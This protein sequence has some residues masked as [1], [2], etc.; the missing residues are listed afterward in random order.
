MAGSP[1]LMPTRRALMGAALLGAG[2]R[3]AAAEPMPATY[4]PPKPGDTTPVTLRF[5]SHYVG[6]HPMGPVVRRLLA[7]FTQQYPNVT[8]KFEG[9]PGND[10]Q[11]KIKLDASAD[12]MPDL[13]NYW[14]LDPGFGLDQIVAAGKL[15]DL[16]TWTRTDPFFQ[17]L[18]D[19]YSWQTA[20]LGGKVYGI[21][22]N[23]FYVE[24]LANKAV[25]ERAG[26]K[27]P[28]DW[29]SLLDGVH[30]LKQ[31]GEL[32]W[33]ISIGNDSQGGRIYN[34]VVNRSV[35]NERALAMHSGREPINVPDMVAALARLRDLV[36]GC[37]PADAIS[38][39]NES[40][41]AKYVNTNRGALI[42]DGSWATPTIKPAVQDNLVVMNFPLIPG[43]A[44][45]QPNIE[46]DL[47]GLW[48]MGA[49]AM[50]DDARRPW[51]LQLIRHL[52]SRQAAKAYVEEAN[53]QVPALGVEF[54]ESKIGRV[55]REAQTLALSV[56]GNKWIPSVMK[57]TQRAKFEPALGEFLSGK[58]QP[59]EFAG[60]LGEI[61][62]A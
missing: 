36:V 38:I 32:P 29:A 4:A 61:F 47:T 30:A 42:I 39:Q 40:V 8:I 45:K 5:A 44:Q 13:F 7:S 37:V 6:V 60:R 11:T 52:S 17:G 58:Y 33:A 35:G 55:A 1:S 48:Y 43:G 56:P 51:V 50:A 18:F 62:A 27:L 14:R 46:R 59:Q 19:D 20:S 49:A 23:M 16:T 41:Y 2:L 34:Y 57:P 3:A 22:L 10:H 53:T 26:V 25:F 28:T 9:T 31:K 21:P 24:F 15:A 54:D 12:R